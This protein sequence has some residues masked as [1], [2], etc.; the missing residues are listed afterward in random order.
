MEKKKIRKNSMTMP[1]SCLRQ[2]QT[3]KLDDTNPELT[4]VLQR[5]SA[6]NTETSRRGSSEEYPD[7]LITNAF[8]DY[9]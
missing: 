5:G 1:S 7:R 9:E 2:D 4:S 6:E 8:N 3:Q